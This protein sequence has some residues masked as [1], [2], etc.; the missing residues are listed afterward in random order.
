VE[1]IE[2]L[3]L[4]LVEPLHLDVEDR[5]G[6]Q[7]QPQRVP[8]VVHQALLVE[9]LHRAELVEERGI[10]RQR[11]EPLELIEVPHPPVTDPRGDQRREG[12]IAEQEPAPGRHSV[13]LVVEA[14]GEELCEVGKHVALE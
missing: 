4:V 8:N 5:R 10:A 7:V 3:P 6:V 1:R 13:G 11:L 2:E 14:L 12:G 9:L